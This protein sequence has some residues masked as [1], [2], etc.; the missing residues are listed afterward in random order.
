MNRLTV[1]FRVVK[2]R[3]NRNLEC[4]IFV[5]ITKNGK[6][7]EFSTGQYINPES[8]CNDSQK[9][10]DKKNPSSRVINEYIDIARV[11]LLEINNK[12][13]LTGEKFSVMDIKEAF[14]GKTSKLQTLLNVYDYYVTQCE[15]LEKQEKF[16]KG[17]LKRYKVFKGKLTEFLKRDYK[18]DDYLLSNLS[19]SFITKFRDFL[20]I[21]HN[22]DVGTT[23]VYLKILVRLINVA[24]Q[25]EWLKENPFPKFKI[26]NKTVD[27]VKLEKHEIEAIE[28]KEFSTNRLTMIRDVFLFCIYTGL[29]HADVHKLSS[30]N[31]VIGVDGNRWLSFKRRKTDVPNPVPLHPKAEAILEK[32]KHDPE[33]SNKDRVL[34]VKANQKMNEYLKEIADVC[35]INKH[36]TCHI[37]RHTFA[38]TVCA[39]NGVSIETISKLLGHRSIRTTQIYA[40]MSE[41][42]IADEFSKIKI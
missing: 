7:T 21:E 15:K 26:E 30:S 4:P 18:A 2:T 29:A 17:R 42:R 40:K 41:K 12:L 33:C 35:G 20:V 14:L 6:R 39:N 23:G 9:M 3:P 22:L 36:L 19:P 37:A 8:W 34:P 27:R 25:N 24:L 32:Y 28:K 11:K 31:I 5:R 1:G 13:S 16:S 38:T 10:K